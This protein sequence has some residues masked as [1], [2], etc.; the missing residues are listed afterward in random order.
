M[1][2]LIVVS[3]ISEKWMNDA[4]KAELMWKYSMSMTYKTNNLNSMD[5]F[6]KIKTLGFAC[7]CY[8]N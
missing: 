1:K 8:V 6:D 5:I 7:D 2:Y 3:L 4:Y